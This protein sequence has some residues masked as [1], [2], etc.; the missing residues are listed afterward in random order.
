MDKTI[1]PMDK[2]KLLV[3]EGTED[4]PSIHLDRNLGIY[5][6]SGRSLPE[7]VTEFYKPVLEWLEDFSI[8]P[9]PEIKFLIKL[10]YFNTASS[11]LLL[12]IMMKLEDIHSSGSS[13]IC[14]HWHFMNGDD[15]MYEA[16]EEYKDLISVPFE[17]ISY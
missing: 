5:M 16:G 8:A 15:D 7:D 6:I 12:D 2:I 4:T 3:M 1:N 14:I 10:E 11:K 13:N 17:L 9:E